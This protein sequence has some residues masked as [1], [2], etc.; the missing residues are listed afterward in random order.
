MRFLI[1]PS[2]MFVLRVPPFFSELCYL[3]YLVPVSQTGL[4]LSQD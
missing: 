3:N 4:S 2:G 1:D